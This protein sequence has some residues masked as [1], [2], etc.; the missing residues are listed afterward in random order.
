MNNIA[1][2]P[3]AAAV[4][5]HRRAAVERAE[6]AALR[7]VG[8]LRALLEEHAGNLNAVA[9]RPNSLRM[10]RREYRMA[11]DRRAS[12]ALLVSETESSRQKNRYE[13][14][15][16]RAYEMDAARIAKF[17]E[18]VRRDASAGFDA[19]VAKLTAKVG[20][21][22]LRARVDSAHL[23]E[24]SILDVD[25]TDGTR[26]RWRTKMIL[27]VSVLGKLFNQWPTRRIA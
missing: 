19:Y 16:V 1:T 18:R 14:H 6:E 22:A 7:H 17:V 9:P 15:P 13:P 11:G 26:E 20:P 24:G 23:W 12:F 21:G 3:I 4:E 10:G 27:N 8:A 5:H 2:N 25:K